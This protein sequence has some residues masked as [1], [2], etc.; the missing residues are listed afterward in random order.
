LSVRFSTTTLAQPWGKPSSARALKASV[1][2][3][4]RCAS[5][6]NL[7]AYAAQVSDVGGGYSNAIFPPE[8]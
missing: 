4:R 1:P 3:R 6:Q 8:T 5:G 2:S 7:R